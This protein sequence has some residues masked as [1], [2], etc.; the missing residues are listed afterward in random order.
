MQGSAQNF[1]LT[2]ETKSDEKKGKKKAKEPESDNKMP[3]EQLTSHVL[4]SSAAPLKNL[5]VKFFLLLLL[6]LASNLV[7]IF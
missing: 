1:D 2:K 7:S 4:S 3:V 6:N 5:A